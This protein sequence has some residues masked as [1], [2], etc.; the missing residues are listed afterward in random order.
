MRETLKSRMARS[1][2]DV[3]IRTKLIVITMVTTATA[4]VV[5]GIGVVT[6]ESIFFRAYLL[7]D[8]PTLARIIGDNSTAALSFDDDA[9]ATETLSALRFRAHVVAACI[10]RN[11]GTALARYLRAPEGTPCP[12]RMEARSAQSGDGDQIHSTSDALIISHPVM[13]RGLRIGTL[14]LT[15]DFDELYQQ[16]ELYGGTVFAVL[17]FA[18]LVAFILSAKLRALIATPLSSLART[19]SSVSESKDYRIRA[20][21]AGNDELGILVDSFNAMLSG[22]QS[23]DL[24]LRRAL[25]GREEALED[26]KNARDSLATTLE[27]IGDAVLSTDVEGRIVLV[28]TAAKALLRQPEDEMIGKPLSEVVQ[29][30]DEMSG[31]KVD[32]PVEHVLRENNAAGMADHTVLLAKDATETPIDHSGAPIRDKEG[33]ICGT[34]LVFRDATA[35]RRA[36]EVSRLLAAIV[37][38]S[39]DAIIGQTLDGRVTS[40]NKGAERIFGY[41]EEEMKG[42]STLVLSPDGSDEMPRV[43]EQIRRGER[44]GQYL[45]LRRTRDKRRI[46]VSIAVS[47][48]YDALGRTIGASTIA[49]DVTQQVTATERLAE[50]NADLKTSNERLAR[51][52]EDLERFAF[53]ASHDFQEPLRMISIYAQLLIRSCGDQLDPKMAGYVD[54]VVFGTRRIHELLADLMAFAEVGAQ[55]EGEAG[56]LDLNAVLEKVRQTLSLSITENG[57]EIRADRLPIIKGYERHFVALFQNLISNA[58][59]YRS[60]QPPRA[61]ISVRK[62]EGAWEFSVADNGIGIAPEFHEKV[63]VAFKR[64]NGPKIPG[65]GIGLAICQRVV[66]RYG[67]TIRVQSELGAGATF[68]FTLPLEAQAET[69]EAACS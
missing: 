26:A 15:Y 14:L 9:A 1:F 13:L 27:S 61:E 63:F 60:E 62:V 51:S 47:P 6:L 41:E 22:I 67:G 10:Y 66:E 39:N 17:L 40:W 59:K 46:H 32:N 33:Q 24:D 23:R 43:L 38:S 21:K 36:E 57:A 49:R 29:L 3:P 19:A 7:R 16:I 31:E 5:A 18:S 30:I 8:L 20:P 64:L 4:L 2:A 53:I 45:A 65:T 42:R 44:V 12:V 25:Q 28:N 54:H 68:I 11:D 56:P 50:L 37:Q 55:M 48:L 34:V 69:K 58:I 35:R 52:N